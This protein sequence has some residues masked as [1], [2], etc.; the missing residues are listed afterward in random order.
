MR[1][2]P[3][4]ADLRLG[5]PRMSPIRKSSAI[6]SRRGAKPSEVQ[7]H[8]HTH[9]DSQHHKQQNNIQH[10][11]S[12]LLRGRKSGRGHAAKRSGF[13]FASCRSRG[14]LSTRLFFDISCH[15]AVFGRRDSHDLA[16][17]CL[18]FFGFRPHRDIHHESSFPDLRFVAQLTHRGNVTHLQRVYATPA[19]FWVWA[20]E[21]RV[22]RCPPGGS[23][24]GSK[25][26]R[27]S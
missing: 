15:R 4:E 19:A 9:A 24:V 7:T 22:P 23:F 26:P 27:S 21:H 11:A 8:H 25:R 20:R 2:E 6:I 12:T 16:P 5:D 14:I 1:P 13:R 17:P 3:T 10:R 18:A